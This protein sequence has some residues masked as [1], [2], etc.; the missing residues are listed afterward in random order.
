MNH[1]ADG[2]YIWQHEDLQVHLLK[3]KAIWLEE[4]K[5][6]LVSDTHFGKAGHFRKSGIPIPETI[7]I[8]DYHKIYQLISTLGAQKVY[9]LGDLFHSDHNET[10]ADLLEF[11]D[12]NPTVNFHLV[13]GNHDIL[14]AEIYQSSRLQIHKQA[15][16]LGRF[17]LSH[18]PLKQVAEG[19][20]NIC[21]HLHP[22]LVIKGKSKQFLKLPC[23]YYTRNCLIMPAF[24]NFT[25]LMK[26]SAK[27]AEALLVTTAEAVIPIKLKNKVG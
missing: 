3:E 17:V 8:N 6:L 2:R 5:S 21:G 18:E 11:L 12:E 19:K 13:L 27:T 9:F 22:G 10:W 25:G 4:E 24:G 23:Y 1:S 7:H 15:C 26:M 14:P 20:L 16:I